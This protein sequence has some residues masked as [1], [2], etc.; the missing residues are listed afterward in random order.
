MKK[1]ILTCVLSFVAVIS[2]QALSPAKDNI[3]LSSY[4]AVRSGNEMTISF[5]LEVGR[6]AA[7]CGYSVLLI[8]VITDGEYVWA[9]QPVIAQSRQAR[10]AE[11]RHVMVSGQP[12][13]DVPAIY[14]DMNTVFEYTVTVPYQGWM[15]KA[16]LSVENYRVG[17]G[18]FEEM[19]TIGFA[20]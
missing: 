7:P 9:L 16:A 20:E 19:E 3:K 14:I 18:S 11:E 1:I 13:T 8:P 6:K 15:D 17:C 5:E 10:I 2:A 12:E 4:N